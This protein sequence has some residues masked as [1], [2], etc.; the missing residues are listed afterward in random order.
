VQYLT[1][2]VREDR[3]FFR[4]KYGTQYVLDVIKQ[5]YHN[6]EHSDLSQ[7]DRKT[8]RQALLGIFKLYINKEVTV[9]DMTAMMGFLWSVRDNEMVFFKFNSQFIFFFPNVF[10]KYYNICRGVILI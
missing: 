5:H 1:N 2:L 8:M 3:S 7:D 10:L 6:E 9:S 4:K